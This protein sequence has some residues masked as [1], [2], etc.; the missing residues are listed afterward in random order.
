[1]STSFDP[2][3][4]DDVIIGTSGADVIDERTSLLDLLIRGRGGND[5]IRSGR[6]NDG[7]L[8]GGGNDTY[9]AGVGN[10]HFD[11]QGGNDTYDAS[12]LA[13]S[14]VGRFVFGFGGVITKGNNLGTDIIGRFELNPDGTI[15]DIVPVENVIAPAGKGDNLVSL[16]AQAGD[17]ALAS[18]EVDLRDG[19]ITVTEEDGGPSF[20]VDISNFN[21]II[22]TNLD[23]KLRGDNQANEI[24]GGAGNDIIRGRGGDDELRGQGGNDNIKGNNGNDTIRGGGGNDVID[25]G[26]GD[27]DLLGNNGNDRFVGSTGN[28]TII[29][30][31][32]F[33]TADYSKLGAPITFSQA[34]RIFKGEDGALGVDQLGR[35]FQFSFIEEVIADAAFKGNATNLGSNTLDNSGGSNISVAVDL[36]AGDITATVEIEIPGI[37]GVIDN[38]PAGTEFT[39]AVE[40]FGNAFGTDQFADTLLGDGDAN[41]LV[42]G[43]GND[44]LRG[45]GGNDV[46]VGGGGADTIRA[47]GGADTIVLT[48]TDAADEIRNVNLRQDDFLIAI[49][50]VSSVVGVIAGNALNLVVNDGGIFN[51][52]TLATLPGEAANA[53]DLMV[54]FG[55]FDPSLLV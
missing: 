26:N 24:F 54:S 23:D 39:V 16:E 21:D 47:G 3:N 46:L 35:D 7:I 15:A 38:I 44:D 32:G 19:F 9:F 33:D 36:Q 53:G 4:F 55:D 5:A 6:G 48:D 8:G 14:I 22:G 13:N 27:D 37:P 43:G 29:G 2:K 25:G 49:A 11:G 50:G 17:I 51:N 34:G 20:T 1:M 12:G 42:G 30:D 18:A 41:L 40:N 52:T 28:D 45:R 10:D 31:A